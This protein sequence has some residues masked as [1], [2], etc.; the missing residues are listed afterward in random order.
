MKEIES[1]EMIEELCILLKRLGYTLK[2]T[3]NKI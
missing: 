2:Y 3:E 1:V